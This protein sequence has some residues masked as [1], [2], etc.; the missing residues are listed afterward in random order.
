MADATL[1][2]PYLRYHHFMQ[3]PFVLG[4]CGSHE[5][6]VLIIG[7]LAGW[8]LVPEKELLFF[9]QWWVVARLCLSGDA[10]RSFLN[11]SDV[12]R[13][14]FPHENKLNQPLCEEKYYAK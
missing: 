2:H 13:K 10:M 9:L 3:D 7:G 4:P 12:K 6:F 8:R 5:C 14:G 11:L 1:S